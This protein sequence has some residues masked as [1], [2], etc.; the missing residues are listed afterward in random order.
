[1]TSNSARYRF[2]GLVLTAAVLVGTISVTSCKVYAYQVTGSTTLLD[3]IET[4][5]G[6]LADPSRTQRT[7][8]DAAKLLLGKNQQAVTKILEKFL[9]DP[10]NPGAQIAIANAISQ[11]GG[12]RGEFAKPLLAML[13]GDNDSVRTPA[14][15]A[16]VTFRVDD[17]IEIA[18]DREVDEKIRLIAIDSL[19]RVVAKKSIQTLINLLG[20]RKKA[21]RNAALDSLRGL[22]NIR[23]FGGSQLL[24]RRWW[25][26]NKDKD[27]YQWLLAMTNLVVRGKMGLEHENARLRARL[28]KSMQEVYDA[29]AKEQ[30]PAILLSMLND[31]LSDIRLLGTT[32]I[33]KLVL[34]NEPI[35]K[36]ISKR[37][38]LM[39]TD[40]D[41]RV[42]N[43]V[44]LLS[45]AVPD[46]RTVA[47]LRNRLAREAHPVVRVGLLRAL[48]NLKDQS[49]FFDVLNQIQNEDEAQARAAALALGQIASAK[50]LNKYNSTRAARS[51]NSRYDKALAGKNAL[52][53]REAL[54]NAMSIIADPSAVS[55]FKSALKD[56]AAVIRLAGVTGLTKLKHAASSAEIAAHISDPDRG[57]RQAVLNAIATLA[58][59]EYLLAILDRTDPEIEEDSAIRTEANRWVLDLAKTADSKMHRKILDKLKTRKDSELRISMRKIFV[60]ELRKLKDGKLALALNALSR[61]LQIANRSVEA[62]TIA[63]EAYMLAAAD[64]KMAKHLPEFWQ[65]YV[66]ALIASNQPLAAKLVATQKDKKLR[67]TAT[68]QYQT[69]LKTLMNAKNYLAVIKLAKAALENKIETD[70]WSESKILNLIDQA[71]KAQIIVDKSLVEKLIPE[72]TSAD[73][74]LRDSAQSQI[75]QLGVRAVK[76]LI[77]G[78]RG[79][80]NAKPVDTK[81]EQAILELLMQIDPKLT[82]YDTKADIKTRLDRIDYWLKNLK[83]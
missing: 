67:E 77:A 18:Q 49:V 8:E 70:S 78:L 25:Q 79:A 48:G 19:Q 73:N 24:W 40:D 28:V 33:A 45:A 16:L 53:L 43:A 2:F 65:N 7:R 21:V 27:D 54:L 64:T 61:D 5:R 41:P 31:P 32:L 56:P 68:M 62:V 66:T 20:D 17:L 44:A 26:R 57:V 12:A 14:A 82:G 52:A 23:S 29:S 81:T 10:S 1:M 80:L 9:A 36:K 59:K 72:L 46:K 83:E 63:R 55:V 50:P 39:L 74:S 47:V 6:Q 75:K 15:R 30:K 37:L 4:L 11:V 60:A 58:G 13:K 22:T 34:A 51:L 35:E 42:R 3:E 76:P 71:T 38:R 69:Q